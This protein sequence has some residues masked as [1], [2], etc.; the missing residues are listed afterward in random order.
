MR[1]QNILL[2]KDKLNLN[3]FM[4]SRTGLWPGR[5]LKFILFALI[6][7]VLCIPANRSMDWEAL[8]LA[9]SKIYIYYRNYLINGNYNLLQ[10]LVK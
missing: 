1:P 9:I 3:H 10:H 2:L 5:L 8:F 6:S 4:R 7:L